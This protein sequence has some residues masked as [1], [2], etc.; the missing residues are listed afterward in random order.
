MFLPLWLR[1]PG[2]RPLGTT[3]ARQQAGAALGAVPLPSH[4]PPLEAWRRSLPDNEP[5]HVIILDSKA[6]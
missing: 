1:A 6:G 3:D 4:I 2:Y 5:H